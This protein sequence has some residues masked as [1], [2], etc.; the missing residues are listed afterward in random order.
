MYLSLY[1]KGLKR[2]FK[3]CVWEGVGDR[4][5]TAIFWPQTYGHQGCVFLVLHGCSTGGQGA[6]SAGFWLSLLHLI[7]I[8]SGPQFIRASSPFGLVWLSL[9]QLASTGT[10]TQLS[11]DSVLS[12]LYNNSTSTRS[13]TRSLKLNVKSSSSRNNCHAVHRSIS[14]GALVYECTM[15]IFFSSSYFISWFPPTQFPLITA[16]RMCHLLPVH[17]PE[18]HF[19]P[20]RR[21]KYYTFTFEQ[22][23]LEMLWS[24]LSSKQWVK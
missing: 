13:P 15:G 21:S 12:A 18:W 24:P 19:W 7:S 4:T 6:H 14:S 1:W 22:I 10:R 2:L 17:H 3:V 23:H 11:L 20:G 16:I 5:E 8:F 9:P